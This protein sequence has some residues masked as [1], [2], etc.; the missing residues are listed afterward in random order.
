[1]AKLTERQ[2]QAARDAWESNPR[3]G[4]AWLVRDLGLPV[5][6]AAISKRAARDG[7][8][9]QPDA[10]GATKQ[11]TQAVTE[12]T[13]NS[14]SVTKGP[15][16]PSD[17]RPEFTDVAYNL[18]LLGF[19]REQLAQAFGVDERTIY[20]WQESY[21]EFCQA[22]YKGGAQ[23]D[24]EVARALFDR[25]KGAVV[26]DTHISLHEGQ[27]VI[28]P[29]EKHYP[30]DVGAARLWLKNRQ[31]ELWKDKVEVVEQPSIALVDKEAM[32]QLYDRVLAEAAE[33]REALM[34]RAE[35]MGL[36]LD[37]ERVRDDDV[38]IG[39]EGREF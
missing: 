37:S 23:A 32:D 33:K 39:A 16:R 17:Y 8:R 28:T 4:Y 15:G 21:P 29:L 2:W 13:Q 35:R 24:A 3:D 18:M 36:V 14:R 12:V 26:P 5:S 20:R 1:M 25:A 9:K 22:L 30:P 27:P 38:V 31:P 7:W 6:R 19:T 34:N 11:V 10:K